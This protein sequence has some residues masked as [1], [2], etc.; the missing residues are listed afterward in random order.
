MNTAYDTAVA[1]QA[2]AVLLS[3]PDQRQEASLELV[4]RAVG[5][6]GDSA[7]AAGLGRA[8]DFVRGT[9]RLELAAQ[10]VDTFDRA[11]RRTL[12]MTYYTDG[13][14]RRRGHGLAEIKRVYAAAGWRGD[15]EELPDHLCLLLEFAAR[16][17]AVQGQR[18][19]LQFQPG[20]ELLR[21]GLHDHGCGWAAVLDAVAATLPPP[22]VAARAEAL[23]I[24]R[25]PPPAENVGLQGYGTVA[26]GMPSVGSEGR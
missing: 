7:A 25:Q 20:I 17:D 15:R 24:A 9:A 16:A 6:L 10:Y 21:S 22:D 4:A 26:L 11:R 14:T 8:V 13:D 1:R 19:L 3:Y 18:L 12:H 2:A 23:R 5:E